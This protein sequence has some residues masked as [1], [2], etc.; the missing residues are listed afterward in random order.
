MINIL[1]LSAGE[2]T[3]IKTIL[4]KGFSAS[5]STEN[6]WFLLWPLSYY[7][8]FIKVIGGNR[9]W[10]SSFIHSLLLASLTFSFPSV[11]TK[12]MRKQ[13]LM[14]SHEK[15]QHYSHG[16]CA[17]RSNHVILWYGNHGAQTQPVC[18]LRWVLVWGIFPLMGQQ[19]S[20]TLWKS[21]RQ[22]HMLQS[23]ITNT[24]Y[25]CGEALGR[26]F[27]CLFIFFKHWLFTL[28]LQTRKFASPGANKGL[29][30]FNF[31]SAGRKI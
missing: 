8:D 21:A 14:G 20:V 28:Q 26:D 2:T 12:M 7:E 22:Q 18:L 1:Y 11:R 19:S 15:W 13:F 3:L 10:S 9:V 24:H 16:S 17:V 6:S 31:S 25:H 5:S 27:I 29:F 4:F 23:L 30:H